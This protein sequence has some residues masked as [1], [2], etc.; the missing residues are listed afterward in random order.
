MK[1]TSTQKLFFLLLTVVF[2]FFSCHPEDGM[3][4][5]MGPQGPE[6]IQGPKGDPGEDYTT[7][8]IMAY[9]KWEIISGEFVLEHSKY[10]YINED[11][12]I[13]ILAED[14]LGFKND[15]ATNVLLTKD[16]I[17]L[18]G[19]EFSAL[20]N[21]YYLE[22]DKMTIIPPYETDPVVM[23][24]R[25]NDNEASSWIKD[26]TILNE[27]EVSWGRDIDIAFDG[28]YILGYDETERQILKIDTDN[29]TVAETITTPNAA[30][31]VEIEKSN[32][33]QRQL[34]QS[35]DGYSQFKSYIY[36]SNDLYYTSIEIGSW[37]RGIASIEPGYLW[38]SSSNNS[39]LYHYKSNGSLTP[40]EILE[41]IPLDFQPEGL[42]YQDGFLYVTERNRVHKCETSPN[43]RAVETFKLTGGNVKGIAY[44]GSNFW[45]STRTWAEYG[46]KLLKVD[47]P[48]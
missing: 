16:Q 20:I 38:A 3:D 11:N 41:T 19:G 40:G 6:G 47:L 1:N 10:V 25:P 22:G 32:T 26:I 31:V 44:D 30:Y 12:T 18:S 37:I 34:F 24:R 4:G 27:G 23:E 35:N 45:L 5:A 21:N 13:A 36:A 8:E 2:L 29:F 48:N 14:P 17:T 33:A 15:L 43:F 39:A 28:T 7:Q 42:D 9:G 46:Y